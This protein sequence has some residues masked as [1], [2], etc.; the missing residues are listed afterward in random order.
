MSATGDMMDQKD[1]EIFAL[2]RK[3][4]RQEE[5]ISAYQKTVNR[6]DDYFEY[7][8]ESVSDR[9]EIH[10]ILNGL[11]QTLSTLK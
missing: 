8:N 6:I 2:K 9:E 11:T 10:E 3:V 1:E 7:R 4:H 5:I